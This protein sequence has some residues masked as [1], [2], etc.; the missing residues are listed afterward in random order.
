[1]ENL[2]SIISVVIPCRNE[3]MYIQQCVNSVREFIIPE[4]CKIEILLIDGNSVDKTVEII[5]RL[6]EEDSSIK[7]IQNSDIYQSFAINKALEYSK[8]EWIMRLDAHSVYPRNYLQLCFETAI[9]TKADNVGGLFITLPGGDT[10]QAK[11]VQALTTHK[12]GVGDAG[13]RTGAKEECIADTV[14]Y[15][16]FNKSLFEKIGLLDERLIRAQDYEFNRRISSN[17]GKVWRNSDILVYYYNQPNLIEFYKKQFYKEAPYNVYLWYIAPYAFAIRHAITGVFATGIIIGGILAFFF[18]LM[19]FL[20]LGGVGL[21][22]LLSILSAIQQSVR[23]KNILYILLLPL[24]FFLFH[25]IHGLGVIVGVLKILTNT[26]P[27][28]Q[29]KVPWN[30]AEEFYLKKS[31]KIILPRF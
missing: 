11:L 16:F 12:F 31:K 15:G 24:C 25:F 26:S 23:Y 20:Y 27:V 18:P 2:T 13:F 7:L 8:G 9:R 5:K 22:F 19:M 28:Q 17:G 29:R 10:I 14:P 30:R 3:E 6:Q 1:M 21:Y 4:E